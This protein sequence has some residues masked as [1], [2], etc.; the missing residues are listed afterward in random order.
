MATCLWLLLSGTQF[1]QHKTQ[2][3]YFLWAI[4]TAVSTNALVIQVTPAKQS[5]SVYA[6]PPAIDNDMTV[7]I[8]QLDNDLE[9][10]SL[11]YLTRE[12]VIPFA[13]RPSR[14]L[15]KRSPT[16]T[17]GGATKHHSA[18][19]E[20][21]NSHIN[22]VQDSEDH[23]HSSNDSEDHRHSSNDSQ[24]QHSNQQPLN[25]PMNQT[26]LT[27]PSPPNPPSPPSPQ[28]PTSIKMTKSTMDILKES[29]IDAVVHR[30][31]GER[32]VGESSDKQSS[33]TP[34]AKSSNTPTA[35][36]NDDDGNATPGDKNENLKN[37]DDGDGNTTPSD[38]DT[39]LKNIDDADGNIIPDNN[40]MT[41]KNIDD[42]NGM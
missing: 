34:P 23:H 5:E 29:T 31:V 42:S 25:P 13:I 30:V 37:N 32:H 2:H 36:H 18:T 40:D 27:P 20:H 15:Y 22:A 16:H 35:Q 14:R 28:I 19:H 11:H 33:D 12:S 21:S 38:N 4:A 39:T 1:K 8:K 41:L 6:K 7:I 10:P 9:K 24:N 3:P 17:G 26:P